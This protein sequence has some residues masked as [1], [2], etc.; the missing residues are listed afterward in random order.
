MDLDDIADRNLTV[1]E[2]LTVNASA[3]GWSERAQE[4]G[5]RG[6][7][8]RARRCLPEDC[9]A[10]VAEAQGLADARA[11]VQAGNEH[12]RSTQGRIELLAELDTGRAP[13]CDIDERDLALATIGMITDEATP[14]Y[15]SRSF[16]STGRYAALLAKPHSLDSRHRRD[17]H[18]AAL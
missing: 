8:Q 12:V 17:C 14:S 6:L 9:H 1:V 18:E 5:L 4:S 2:D 13:R 10:H 16:Y 7:H 3:A 15:G 11:E